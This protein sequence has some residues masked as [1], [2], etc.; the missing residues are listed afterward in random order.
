MN[1]LSTHALYIVDRALPVT[2]PVAAI[3]DEAVALVARDKMA[4]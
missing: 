4:R 1:A 3:K 2:S